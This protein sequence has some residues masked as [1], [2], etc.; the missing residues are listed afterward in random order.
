MAGTSALF[1]YLLTARRAICTRDRVGK[2]YFLS[3]ASTYDLLT[4]D[5]MALRVCRV[6]GLPF[7]PSRSPV[8]QLILFDAVDL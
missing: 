1:S 4:A 2:F 8:S 5:R 6:I 3:R 7:M